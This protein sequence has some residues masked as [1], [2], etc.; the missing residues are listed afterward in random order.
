[1]VESQQ[2][3]HK[4]RN[5]LSHT[6]SDACH[7][8]T[9][10][11][12][13]CLALLQDHNDAAQNE[14]R[15]AAF[16]KNAPLVLRDLHTSHREYRHRIMRALT[17]SSVFGTLWTRRAPVMAFLT[18][19]ELN[20][21]PQVGRCFA[22]AGLKDILIGT[23]YI[24]D[25]DHLN[26]NCLAEGKYGQ[27]W[28]LKKSIA[29]SYAKRATSLVVKKIPIANTHDVDKCVNEAH[30]LMKLGGLVNMNAILGVNH[31][32]VPKFAF[33]PRNKTTSALAMHLILD[34]GGVPIFNAIPSIQERSE[35][36]QWSVDLALLSI[37]AQMLMT[38]HTLHG[39]LDVTHNDPHLENV[40][41]KPWNSRMPLAQNGVR[42]VLNPPVV[43]D[44]A[45][46]PFATTVGPDDDTN[47]ETRCN[48]AALFI[49]MPCY[50]ATL[51]DFG[52][53][54]ES[55][56]V[57][58]PTKEFDMLPV[59]FDF[60]TRCTEQDNVYTE[61]Q[62]TA[63][64]LIT[65]TAAAEANHWKQRAQSLGI[66][67]INVLTA[68]LQETGKIVHYLAFIKLDSK[69]R[70]FIHMLVDFYK[71]NKEQRGQTPFG[72][73]L[74]FAIGR[75]TVAWLE[76]AGP[77]TDHAETRAFA[78]IFQQSFTQQIFIN[79]VPEML[80]VW[81][82]D[83][84]HFA[85]V[86]ARETTVHTVIMQTSQKVISPK[87]T[88]YTEQIRLNQWPQHTAKAYQIANLLQQQQQQ[89][90]QHQQQQIK[91]TCK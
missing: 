46:T 83:F 35:G 91:S 8:D 43:G 25:R 38:M 5:T 84:T 75:L 47:D 73:W 89:Q 40:V 53:A 6:Q 50:L 79:D 29:G 57:F 63:M 59:A 20:N 31:V 68:P 9:F 51:I 61:A 7:P 74:V 15:L 44:T 56:K 87:L 49:P 52:L 13:R 90:Q 27:V 72:D 2:G 17:D 22:Y 18:S 21:T 88:A 41:I 86:R 81:Q 82:T 39:S 70:D 77:L 14:H 12:E 30:L 42:Y 54:A 24:T 4:K 71:H 64:E 60:R 85:R 10:T 1:M 69:L 23:R 37:V 55:K 36:Q 3:N 48:S 65:T 78:D 66:F 76:D 80:P 16:W 19:V 45:A 33:S 58:N 32:C 11:K 26:K 28:R 34:Y 67:M 62:S